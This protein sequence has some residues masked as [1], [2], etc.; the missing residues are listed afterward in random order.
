MANPDART[1]LE[2]RKACREYS[3]DSILSQMED[4]KQWGILTDFRYSSF[5]MMPLYEANVLERFADLVQKKLVE[6][7]NRAVFWSVER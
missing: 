6:R 4:Y 7:G 5:T 1:A 2:K 3:R